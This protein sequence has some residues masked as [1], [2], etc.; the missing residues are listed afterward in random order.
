MRVG[1]GVC[2][3]YS[4]APFGRTLCPVPQVRVRLALGSFLPAQPYSVALWF[5]LSRV[6]VHNTIIII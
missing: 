2:T 1:M 4:S 6:T 3:L 5:L